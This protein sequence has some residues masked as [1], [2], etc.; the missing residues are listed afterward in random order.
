MLVEAL[1]DGWGVEPRGTGKR[2]W[3]ELCAAGPDAA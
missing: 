2:M 3:F 1:S